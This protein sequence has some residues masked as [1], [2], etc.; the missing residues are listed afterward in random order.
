M[1]LIAYYGSLSTTC[2]DEAQRLRVSGY[3]SFFDTISYCVVYALV[4]ILLDA[5]HVHIDEFVFLSLPL[6]LTMII[7]LF[8]IKEGEKYGYPENE[9]LVAEKVTF[10]ESL[11]LTFKNKLFMRW[12]LINS[13]TFI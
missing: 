8:L 6:M 7:P 10:K 3:K 13:F 1:S 5:M 11:K 4:P 9:G 12:V 2:C